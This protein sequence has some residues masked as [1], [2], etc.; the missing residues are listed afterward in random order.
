MLI[1]DLLPIVALAINKQLDLHAWLIQFGRDLA[2]SEGLNAYRRI[3][4]AALVAII[5]IGTVLMG[6]YLWKL[7]RRA[8]HSERL[9]LIGT[10]ALMLFV[11]LRSASVNHML[12]TGISLHRP[13][14]AF[15]IAS[16]VFLCFAVWRN[17]R[18][19]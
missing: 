10:G 8:T 7:G 9:V 5:A 17:A 11:L 3:V 2:A 1:A 15:E 13:M 16:L 4:Q 6:R 14:L 18:A 19:H 12:S